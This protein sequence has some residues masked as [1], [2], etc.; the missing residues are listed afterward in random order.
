ME[1]LIRNVGHNINA[2]MKYNSI[3]RNSDDST[4]LAIYAPT[5]NCSRDELKCFS[6]C[7]VLLN[8]WYMVGVVGERNGA[9]REIEHRN[10]STA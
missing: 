1:F 8:S 10:V 5:L 3:F 7:F 4:A 6:K 9:A 2:N